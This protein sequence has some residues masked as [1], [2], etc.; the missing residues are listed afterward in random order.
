MEFSFPTRDQ[1]LSL[2]SES[3]DSRTLDYQRTNPRAYQIM[4]THTKKPLEYNS[5][6]A[7]ILYTI[8]VKWIE[9][10]TNRFLLLVQETWWWSQSREKSRVQ[11]EGAFSSGNSTVEVIPEKDGG[12]PLHQNTRG[13]VEACLRNTPLAVERKKRMRLARY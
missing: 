13:L 2:W 6:G 9:G 5:T 11:E 7:R 1:A 4:R 8:S 12:L 10:Q 3:T